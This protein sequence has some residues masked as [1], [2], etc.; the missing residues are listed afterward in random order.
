[1]RPTDKISI[2]EIETIQLVTSLLSIHYIF[3]DN[4]SSA[5][6]ISCNTLPNLP[7]SNV[8]QLATK[9]HVVLPLTAPVQICQIDRTV[10]L[11][12]RCSYIN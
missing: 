9:L 3:V 10:L 5:F 2:L 11:A 8:S 1:M 4:K 7:A 12:S 6:G